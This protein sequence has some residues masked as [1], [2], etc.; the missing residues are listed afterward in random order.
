MKELYAEKTEEIDALISMLNA[1]YMDL[2]KEIGKE[3]N[4]TFLLEE[5]GALIKDLE[6]MR[7][8]YE[9]NIKVLNKEVEQYKNFL[10]QEEQKEQKR[11]VDQCE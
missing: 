6:T 9:N 7:N 10:V 11:S 5:K 1:G 4:E 2:T 3:L 8:A